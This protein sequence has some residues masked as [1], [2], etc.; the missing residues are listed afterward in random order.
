MIF[1]DN[2]WLIPFVMQILN[3]VFS[4]SY[5]QGLNITYLHMWIM[6]QMKKGPGG[7]PSG[8]GKPSGK[9]RDNNPPNK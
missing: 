7:K 9:G 4:K 6:I 8:T 5:L 2:G 3:S 1:N